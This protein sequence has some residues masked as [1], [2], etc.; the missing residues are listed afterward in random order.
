M[1]ISSRFL[2]S[3]ALACVL[4]WATAAWRDEQ[5]PPPEAL[6]AEV[7]S[8][9]LQ[10]PTAATPFQT[11]VGGV[12]YTVKPLFDYALSGLVVSQHHT[13]VW[14]NWVHEATSDHLNIKDACLIWGRNAATGGYQNVKFSSGQWVCYVEGIRGR[15]WQA[16]DLRSISNNHLLVDRPDL[17]RTL[18][19]ARIGDQVAIR[20]Y[21]AEYTHNHGMAFHRGTSTTRDDVGN[22][23]C[24]TLFVTQ[25]HII[26]RGSGV[27]RL[28]RWVA[29]LGL[30]LVVVAWF[31][32]P[33]RARG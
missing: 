9:P 14:W 16:F 11:T 27:W 17:A 29:G 7:R 33:H 10:T 18:R 23:A 4:L 28:L 21:L 20:G 13:D 31:A 3:A 12:T 15:D 8:E 2:G 26:R 22:G 32:Q 30:L 24:E 5:L 25:A 6:D 19:S 1:A